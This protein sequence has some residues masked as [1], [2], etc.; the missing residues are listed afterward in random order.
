MAARLAALVHMEVEVGSRKE[1]A[2]RTD[3]DRMPAVVVPEPDRP[4][5]QYTAMVR[6]PSPRMARSAQVVGTPE[7]HCNQGKT[8]GYSASAG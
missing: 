6:P 7:Q 5:R 1:L 4:G 3:V 8:P 2:G